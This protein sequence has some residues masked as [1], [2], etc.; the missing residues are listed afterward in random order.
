VKCSCGR[1]SVGDARNWNPDCGVHGL[2][3][4]WWKSPEQVTKRKADAARLRSLQAQA[5]EA[6]RAVRRQEPEMREP[7]IE[8]YESDTEEP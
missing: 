1:L 2:G 6:R 7:V 8:I 3:T 4:P 5:R